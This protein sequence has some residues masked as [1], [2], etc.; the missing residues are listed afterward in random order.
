MQVT[1]AYVI[2]ATGR[3]T[4]RQKGRLSNAI[5]TERNNALKRKKGKRPEKQ[6]QNVAY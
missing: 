2:N 4:D 3:H 1:H 6:V 5:T